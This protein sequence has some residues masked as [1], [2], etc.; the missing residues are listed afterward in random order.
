MTE[1]QFATMKRYP[2][3]YQMLK[4]H[5]LNNALAARYLAKA[6]RGEALYRQIVREAFATRNRTKRRRFQ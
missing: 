5:V 6:A 2:R 1:E 4:R 3:T